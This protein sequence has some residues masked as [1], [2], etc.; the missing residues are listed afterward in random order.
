MKVYE[1]IELLKVCD[2]NDLVVLSKDSEGNGFSPLVDVD[3]SSAYTPE[4]TWY[5]DVAL[6]ELTSELAE[7]GYDEEDVA[8]PDAIPCVILSPVN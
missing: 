6:R 5:G 4:T 8:G 2:P 3:T 7:D 1:L